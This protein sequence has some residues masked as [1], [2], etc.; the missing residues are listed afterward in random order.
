VNGAAS[1]QLRL[2]QTNPL[3]TGTTSIGETLANGKVVLRPGL[4]RSQ[5]LATLRHEGVHS[6]LSVADDASF[7][8]WRQWF[9]VG[10]Y[11]NIVRE[12]T[13][14]ETIGTP[15]AFFSELAVGATGLGMFGYGVYELGDY[16]F[17]GSKQ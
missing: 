11:N 14:F 1:H 5:Q 4:T 13:R 7:A 8:P 2:P 6:Y 12:F 3:L 16:L 9:G 10:A 15:R 17:G